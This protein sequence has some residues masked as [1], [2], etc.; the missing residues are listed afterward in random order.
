[1][2][3]LRHSQVAFCPTK[4]DPFTQRIGCSVGM[5]AVEKTDIYFAIEDRTLAVETVA[6]SHDWPTLRDFT[7]VFSYGYT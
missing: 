2:D 3:N 1:M 7:I 4:D 6:W 5:D